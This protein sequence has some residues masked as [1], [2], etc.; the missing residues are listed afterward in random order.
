VCDWYAQRRALAERALA[1]PDPWHGLVSFL[2]DVLGTWNRTIGGLFAIH[3]DWR[4]RFHAL[5]RDLLTRAR[6][7]VWHAPTSPPEDVTLAVLGVAQTMTI[8][9][10]ASPR[11]GD[12]TS[13]WSWMA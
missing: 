7:P 9:G 2:E 5:I 1:D 8:T 11:Y 12:V 3:P 6:T 13:R 10:R 4:Q